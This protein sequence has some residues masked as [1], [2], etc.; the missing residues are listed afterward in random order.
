MNHTRVVMLDDS[1]NMSHIISHI[2][3]H[4]TYLTQSWGLLRPIVPVLYDLYGALHGHPPCG[5]RPDGFYQ[6]V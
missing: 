3:T 1:Y 5:K 2:M 6:D 4:I